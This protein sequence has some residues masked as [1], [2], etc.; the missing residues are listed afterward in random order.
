MEYSCVGLNNLPDEI[1][2]IILKKLNN[3]DALTRSFRRSIPLTS[4]T[5]A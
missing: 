4:L 2:M 3:L 1:L 5:V